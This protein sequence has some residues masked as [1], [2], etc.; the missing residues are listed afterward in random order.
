MHET[1]LMMAQNRIDDRMR[2]AAAWRR[3]NEA[4]GSR[5]SI[6]W[7]TRIRSSLARPGAQRPVTATTAADAAG[8]CV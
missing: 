4:R 1:Y 2:E 5:T 6:G 3:A 7:P 8:G